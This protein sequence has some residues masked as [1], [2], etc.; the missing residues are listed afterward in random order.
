MQ[1]LHFGV[2]HSTAAA[3]KP[4]NVSPPAH[5][6]CLCSLNFGLC[7]VTVSSPSPL[8][9]STAVRAAASF[10]AFLISFFVWLPRPCEH[11]LISAG[12]P[13]SL[14]GE[15]VVRGTRWEVV[16]A[17]EDKGRGTSLI[18]QPALEIYLINVSLQRRARCQ[19]ARPSAYTNTDPRS[20]SQLT[21][22]VNTPPPHPPFSHF[23]IS[24]PI[25]AST[26]LGRAEES[27][28]PCRTGEFGK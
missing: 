27:Q 3:T 25:H 17:G 16:E 4:T 14:R 28:L 20:P 1:L 10:P 11:C 22:E 2:K 26:S 5:V 23:F 15:K 24:L 6:S 21:A 8:L 19:L 18:N 7:A 13:C 9:S 12:L